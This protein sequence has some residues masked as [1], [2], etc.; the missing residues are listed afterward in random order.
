MRLPNV[1]LNLFVVFDTVYEERNLTKAGRILHITQPAVS[2]ALKRLRQVFNDPLFVRVPRGVSPTPV[3]DNISGMV[4][5]ALHLLN[6]SITESEKFLPATSDKTFKFSVHDIDEAVLIPKLMER[7]LKVAPRV[8]IE[9]YSIPRRDVEGELAAG[10]IDFALDVPLFASPQ[11]C[12]RQIITDRY[13]CVIRN[14]HPQVNAS[15]TL[16]TYLE[17][18]HVHV[19]ARRGGIGHVDMALDH[20][21]RRRNIQLRMKNHIA[22]PQVVAVTDLALT[23]PRSVANLAS[24]NVLELPFNVET[25]NQ[26][27]YWH[28]TADKDQANIWMRNLLMGVME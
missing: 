21:G 19:S 17:L 1:D 15:L 10:S 27:L 4:K 23:I 28:K 12:S 13:V 9:C 26:F 22:A 8:S 16:E 25:V 2:N 24:L 14:G 18:Q 3:A 20:L 7:L 5:E 6:N 11:L